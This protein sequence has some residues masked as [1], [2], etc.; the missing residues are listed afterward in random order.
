MSWEIAKG[1][2]IADAGEALIVIALLA[3]STAVYHVVRFV[4][5]RQFD[6]QNKTNCKP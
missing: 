3:V 5:S 6:R 2:W 1:I 4:T